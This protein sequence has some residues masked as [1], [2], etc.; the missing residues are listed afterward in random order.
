MKSSV[1]DRRICG[2]ARVGG[3]GAWPGVLGGVGMEWLWTGVEW[4]EREEEWE[5]EA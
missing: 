3:G 5:G 4:E 2:L 1:L